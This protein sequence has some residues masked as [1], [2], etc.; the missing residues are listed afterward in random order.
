M[1]RI[2]Q[3]EEEETPAAPEKMEVEEPVEEKPTTG[4]IPLEPPPPDF[5]LDLPPLGAVGL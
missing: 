4:I 3:G 1:T 5:I 2:A